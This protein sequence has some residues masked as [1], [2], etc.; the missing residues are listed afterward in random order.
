MYS[1]VISKYSMH[2]IHVQVRV[3]ALSSEVDLNFKKSEFF[4]KITEK[5]EQ[6]LSNTYLVMLFY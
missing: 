4:F 2:V 3:R 6:I 5:S 1:Y